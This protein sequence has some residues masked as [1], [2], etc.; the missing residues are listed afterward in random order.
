L[1]KADKVY[2]EAGME[3]QWEQNGSFV[4]RSKKIEHIQSI[5]T[6]ITNQTE[7]AQQTR[8]R[9]GKHSHNNFSV[10]SAAVFNGN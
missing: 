8:H 2:F 6:C 3:L 9:L 7:G 10:E 1:I 5:S 4:G